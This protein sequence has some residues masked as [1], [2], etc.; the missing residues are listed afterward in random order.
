MFINKRFIL[1]SSSR[2]RYKILKQNKLTF[3][4]S[5]PKCDEEKIKKELIKRKE[6]PIN[7]VKKLAREKA[8][9]VS[10]KNPKTIT[11]GCDTIILLNNKMV[12]KATDLKT[13]E[14]KILNM[15]GKTHKIISV[16]V[17]YKY[18]ERIWEHDE[19]TFVEIRKLSKKEVRNY[20]AACGKDILSSVG[21]YQIERLGPRII[22]K[23]SGDFFNVMG[24]PLFPVLNFLKRLNKAK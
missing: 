4:Q 11:I 20:L 18:N 15:S 6:K 10:L 7:V 21:C 14:K 23:I 17:A 9:S 1:A 3:K 2:S 16:V 13:A 24:L 19:T 8:I 5:K 12:H 22:K